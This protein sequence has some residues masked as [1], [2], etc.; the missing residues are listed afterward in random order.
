MLRRGG[1]LVVL[2]AFLT[3]GCSIDRI[4]WESSGF[5]VEEVRHA[6]EEEHGAESPSVECIKREVGGSLFE[7]RAHTAD[8]E[9]DCEVKVGIREVIHEIDCDRKDEGGHEPAAEEAPAEH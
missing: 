5:P 6:L 1:L 4:Q 7:C 3:A 2:T 9:F 8:A